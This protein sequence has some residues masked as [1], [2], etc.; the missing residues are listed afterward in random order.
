MSGLLRA[1]VSELASD[2]VAVEQL[3]TLL[4]IDSNQQR[5]Q[6]APA[7][8]VR[9]LAEEI[10]RSERS[11]RDAITRG[12][13]KAVKRGRGYLIPAT[14]VEAWATPAQ[15]PTSRATRPSV[16]RDRRRARGPM[17]RGLSGS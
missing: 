1:L 6:P 12:E 15:V 11:V 5:A 2:P 4:E 17:R 16:H 3:R 10:G 9:S 13:L 14:A 8:T 7:F